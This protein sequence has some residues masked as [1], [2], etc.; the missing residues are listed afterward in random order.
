[1]SV[2]AVG[3]A[4]GLD[5]PLPVE[6]EHS[7]LKTPGVL[8]AGA[9]ERWLNGVNVNGYPTGPP[10]LWE[11]CSTGTYRTKDEGS[12]ASVPRFDPIVVYVPF[13]CSSMGMGDY[14]PFAARARQVLD[15]TLSHGIEQALAAGVVL[16]TNP[17][18]GD[19]NLTALAGGVAV[20]PAIGLRYLENAIGS[21]TGRQGLIH[22]TPAVV[23][24]WGAGGGLQAD[25][26]LVTTAGTPVVSGSG[27]IGVDPVNETSPGAHTDWAFATGQVAV[28][29]QEAADLSV[30]EVIDRSD[31]TVV[32]RAEQFALVEW[33]T[34]VQVGVLI[35]WA[36]TP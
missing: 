15:A 7:L 34:S 31:N 27:Y 6:R 25:E 10:K 3:P 2:T 22:A 5:G 30:D 33:D 11:P 14:G 9:G 23:D 13:Q 32:V 12:E 17:S 8:Q 20:S 24:A 28:Y 1:M 36:L 35:D 29:T 4:L 26:E 21:L 16:S 19:S 18:L